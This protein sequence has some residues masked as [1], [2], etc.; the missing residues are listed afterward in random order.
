MG[1][2][3]CLGLELAPI[4]ELLA[5]VASP[6]PAPKKILGKGKDIGDRSHRLMSTGWTPLANRPGH[7]FPLPPAWAAA[8]GGELSVSVWKP[9]EA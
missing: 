9:M 8:N 4:L 6:S 1:F 2:M 7:P 5:C 3:E